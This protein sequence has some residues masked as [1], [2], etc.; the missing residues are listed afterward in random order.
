MAAVNAEA[1]ASSSHWRKRSKRC[2][3]DGTPRRERKVGDMQPRPFRLAPGEQNLRLGGEDRLQHALARAEVLGLGDG[4]VAGAARALRRSEA[5]N[6]G[7]NGE[8]D[9]AERHAEREQ[10]AEVVD[11][12]P[13]REARPEA[14]SGRSAAM[15]SELR[16]VSQLRD[17]E[18]SAS[19]VRM[20]AAAPRISPVA[21]RSLSDERSH[22][23][24]SGAREPYRRIKP[25]LTTTATLAHNRS[26]LCLRYA[27]CRTGER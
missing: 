11:R 7:A 4:S 2:G 14:G 5:D 6:G 8:G 13:R 3:S 16:S 20:A 15:R 22:E 23:M 17:A 27:R 9:D 24:T 19:P 10:H 18:A 21:S 12:R 1:D 26:C 25:R